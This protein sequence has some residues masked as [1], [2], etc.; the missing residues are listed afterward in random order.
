MTWRTEEILEKAEL[1]KPRGLDSVD[2][3]FLRGMKCSPC[4]NVGFAVSNSALTT[5]TTYALTGACLSFHGNVKCFGML[6]EILET[7]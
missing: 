3:E 5:L 2:A 6:S 1:R 4:G 7:S